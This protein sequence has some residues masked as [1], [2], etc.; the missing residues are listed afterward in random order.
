MFN[1]SI[2]N[3]NMYLNLIE[4]INVFRLKYCTK[5]LSITTYHEF[6]KKKKIHLKILLFYKKKNKILVRGKLNKKDG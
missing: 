1:K 5:I 2:L 3:T 4:K 6:E